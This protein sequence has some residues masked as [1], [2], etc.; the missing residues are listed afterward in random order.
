MLGDV[1]FGETQSPVEDSDEF[2]LHLI[3]LSSAILPGGED[4]PYTRLWR[5][6]VGV[7]CEYRVRSSLQKTDGVTDLVS[8]DESTEEQLVEAQIVLSIVA[9]VRLRPLDV[10][11]SDEENGH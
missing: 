7:L 10:D 2:P 4:L 3:H 9:E 1:L 6:V 8:D 11:Q 5:R